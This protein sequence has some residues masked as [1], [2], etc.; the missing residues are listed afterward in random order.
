MPH[1]ATI[2][3]KKYFF[4]NASQEEKVRNKI[5]VEEVLDN[6]LDKVTEKK[7]IYEKPKEK[8][9]CR[10]P[11]RTKANLEKIPE[12]KD[13]EEM[14]YEQRVMYN[15]FTQQKPQLFTMRGGLEKLGAGYHKISHMNREEHAQ[16]LIQCRNWRGRDHWKKIISVMK[17]NE[18]NDDDTRL[19]VEEIIEN[20][21]QWIL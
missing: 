15:I 8:I 14:D 17:K 5:M 20:D 1:K 10:K 4:I 9:I 12:K 7:L 18:I 6:I 21:Y 13:Y 19:V 3:G 11:A 16:A 2:N